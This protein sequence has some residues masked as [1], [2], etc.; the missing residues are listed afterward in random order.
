MNKFVKIS[1]N[2]L[3]ELITAAH[4]FYAL[5]QGGVD[6][7]EWYGASLQDYATANDFKDFN[8]LIESE[9]DTCF[10]L[11]KYLESKP[12]P[13]CPE[14]GHP[15]NCMVSLGSY[16]T[17]SGCEERL[18]SCNNCGSAWNE[19]TTKDGETDLKRHFFG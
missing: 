18:Y 11:E 6:N 7:W 4:Y 2:E 10:L 8:E 3:K 12:A 17:V 5:E 14:C 13:L 9:T 15:L 19:I 1:I 16:E